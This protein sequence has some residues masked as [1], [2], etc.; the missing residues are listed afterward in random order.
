MGNIFD[1][2]RVNSLFKDERFLY[3]EFV[4]ERLP[5]RNKEISE[6]VFCLKPATYGKAPVNVF[7]SG[8]PGTGKTVT[9]KF[10]LNELG[11]FSDRAKC[12]YVNCFEFSTKQAILSRLTNGLGYAVAQRGISF[13]ELYSRFVSVLRSSKVIPIIV[14]DEAEQLL[15]DDVKKSLLYDLARLPEQQ[16]IPIG[17]VFISNDSFFLSRLDE[18]TRSSLQCSSIPF[19]RYS[20]VELKEILNERARF[21]FFDFVLDEDVIPLCAANAAKLGGDARVAISVLLKAGRL[22][23]RE[24]AKKVGVKHVRAALMQEKPV[25][26]EIIFNLTEQEKE[27]LNLLDRLGFKEVDS[28]LIYSSLGGKFSERTLRNAI[29][30]LGKKNLVSFERKVKGR[31][32]TRVIKKNRF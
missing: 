15:S 21:A 1:S 10:V 11:E 12:F 20:V 32:V 30:S 24:N 27:I 13:E 26:T 14:F 4:P 17:L 23:E 6:L 3:P 28:G 22:A 19:S 8:S 18:R 9:I 31:G 25:K 5:F 7:V 16:K 2:A 29:S